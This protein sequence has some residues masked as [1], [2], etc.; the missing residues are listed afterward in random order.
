MVK[1]KIAVGQQALMDG[2]FEPMVNRAAQQLGR[3]GAGKPK[4]YTPEEIKKRTKRLLE[5]ARNK[6]AKKR[7][8]KQK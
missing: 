3:L 1:N 5:A 4:H 6:R 2:K 8:A 7:R